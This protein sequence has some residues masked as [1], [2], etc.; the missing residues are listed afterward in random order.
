MSFIRQLCLIYKQYSNELSILFH[1]SVFEPNNLELGGN[2]T[3]FSGI[4]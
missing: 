3:L 4:Y 1:F 2:K